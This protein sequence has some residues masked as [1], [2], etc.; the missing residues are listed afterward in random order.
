[1]TIGEEDSGGREEIKPGRGRK[2]E[3]I[4]ASA[5]AYLY[6]ST[7]PGWTKK[8]QRR[9]PQVHSRGDRQSVGRTGIPLEMTIVG[10]GIAQKPSASGLHDP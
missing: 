4:R 7:P 2:E 9:D 1:M 10:T 6:L 5:T 8:N 3:T